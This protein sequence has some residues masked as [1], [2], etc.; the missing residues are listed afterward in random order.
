MKTTRVLIVDDDEI[1]RIGVRAI[2]ATHSEYVVCGEA[3]DGEPP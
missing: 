1:V 2:F 3:A